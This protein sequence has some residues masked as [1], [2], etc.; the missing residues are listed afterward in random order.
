MCSCRRPRVHRVGNQLRAHRSHVRRQELLF[1]SAGSVPTRSMYQPKMFAHDAPAKLRARKIQACPQSGRRT[2]STK[3][4][5]RGISGAIPLQAHA[6]FRPSRHGAPCAARPTITPSAPDARK[7]CFG[8][9]Q[10]HDIAIRNHRDRHSILHRPDRCPIGAALVKLAARA[11][12]DRQHL[13]ARRLGT[14][15]NDRVHSDNRRPSQAASLSV[16]GT[17]TAP[18]T[19]SIRRQRMVR[20][21]HQS[22]SRQTARHLLR[23]AAHIDIDDLRAVRLDHPCGLGDP[24]H[25]APGELH[26]R[27]PARRT[28]ARPF[29][30]TPGFA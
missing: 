9:C 28:Q 20:G 5:P 1:A 26:R 2:I 22:R 11:P 27:S 16:T 30:R 29:S 15:R 12:V 6:Q 19:A 13:H 7:G 21:L 8:G 23:G 4:R 25:I 3:S 10:I 18:T 24:I 14:A 17:A